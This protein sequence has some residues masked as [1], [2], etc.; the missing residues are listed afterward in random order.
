MTGIGINV[1]KKSIT[2]AFIFKRL[3]MQGYAI[4]ILP[5]GW[6]WGEFKTKEEAQKVVNVT[7][8]LL[9]VIKNEENT[10]HGSRWV[11]SK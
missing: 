5:Y 7:N 10:L 1:P 9:E 3:D 8:S 11:G 6:T 4:L 2:R